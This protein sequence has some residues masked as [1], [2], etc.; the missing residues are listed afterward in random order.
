M[1]APFVTSGRVLP[2]AFLHMFAQRW[3]CGKDCINQRR[4]ARTR[5]VVAAFVRILLQSCGSAC[6]CAKH[7]ENFGGR[8][9]RVLNEWR[10][11]LE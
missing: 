9:S 10:W 8:C 6:G 7:C 3:R 11:A 4:V 5:A 2:V 1:L